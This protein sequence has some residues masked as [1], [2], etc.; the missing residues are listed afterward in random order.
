MEVTF[1][2]QNKRLAL[3]LVDG[4]VRAIREGIP[5]DVTRLCEIFSYID[6]EKHIE[7]KSEETIVSLIKKETANYNFL[8][9]IELALFCLSD[10]SFIS[11]SNKYLLHINLANCFDQ[12]RLL[13]EAECHFKRAAAAHMFGAVKY[14]AFLKRSGRYQEGLDCLESQLNLKPSFVYRFCLLS[15]KARILELANQKMEALD[16]YYN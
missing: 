12:M 4:Y 9:A 3:S 13:N 15:E 2:P 11:F 14:A 5:L 6:F 7:E 1:W 10:Q 8:F 16:T